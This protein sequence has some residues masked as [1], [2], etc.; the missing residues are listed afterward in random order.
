MSDDLADL[1][2]E[3]PAAA[4]Y[5]LDCADARDSLHDFCGFVEL[6]GVAQ[7]TGQEGKPLTLDDDEDDDAFTYQGIA[8]PTAAHHRLLLDKL[9]AVER[10]EIR[11]LMI[12]MPPGSAKSTYAS[13]AFPAWFMGRKKGRNVGVATYATPLARKIGRRVRSIVRQQRYRDVF[14]LSLSADQGAADEW[15]LENGNEFM[16]AGIMSGWTGNRLDGAVIDDPVKNREEAS[17]PTIQAKVKE[18]FD[19]T[20]NSRLKPGGWVVIIQTRW[21]E[22][23]LSGQI[24][25][26]TWDGESGPVECQDGLVWEVV[27]IP[28]EAEDNDVLGRKPGEMLWPE[29]FG[30]D[31]IFWTAARRNVITWNALYQQRPSAK[32]GTYFKRE[33]FKR[34]RPADI[35]GV[36]FRTY[37]ASDHAPTDSDTSDPSTC[38]VFGIDWRRD[39]YLLGGFTHRETMD[40]TAD[41]I[42]G[43]AKDRER[44]PTRP[45]FEG[46]IRQWRPFAWF[47]EDDNNWKA[48]SPFIYRRIRE[49]GVHIRIEPMSPH[50]SDK[51]T[52]AQS[53]QGMAAS[54]RV[55]IPE[56]VEGDAI[57]EQFVKFPAG[58]HDEEV[59]VAAII[60]R[61]I[62]MA[63]PAIVQPPA[64]PPPPLKGPTDMTLDQ[65]FAM[66]A[67]RDDDRIL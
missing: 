41:K 48:A 61:A 58:K 37:L 49:E 1:I 26:E 59:D 62:D 5:A 7:A 57:I 52:K 20:I 25:P 27:C 47:P 43:N 12:F 17:S 13:V 23:D 2:A 60:G 31:P 10:G 28:A 50:G 39:L 16:G 3:N 55:F 44:D 18:E 32:D 38:R 36:E 33:W 6:P 45:A 30:R 14:G 67:N 56:G 19:A 34:Y 63:H 64:A 40:I 8:R 66:Q 29:W 15:A 22:N 35:Q 53:F 42:V 24:L 4:L 11:R 51:A 9:E 46:L 54:G 21:D 65:L